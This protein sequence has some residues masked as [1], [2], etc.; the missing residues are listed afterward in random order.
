MVVISFLVGPGIFLCVLGLF[1]VSCKKEA[2][3]CCARKEAAKSGSEGGATFGSGERLL[4]MLS[5][6]TNPSGLMVSQ[7][8]AYA[9][10]RLE[11]EFRLGNVGSES[12]E[13]GILER[14]FRFWSLLLSL[15][16]CVLS[17]MRFVSFSVGPAGLEAR[18]AIGSSGAGL[19]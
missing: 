2:P 15:G 19:G 7:V 16:V 6:L 10:S 14:E 12:S 5:V 18:V 11:R 1:V 8:V 9:P 4:C 3:F 17:L 13:T